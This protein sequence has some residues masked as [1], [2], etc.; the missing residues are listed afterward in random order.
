[1][2]EV[3]GSNPVSPTKH[4]YMNKPRPVLEVDIVGL[5]SEVPPLVT[6]DEYLEL[7]GP[8][9]DGAE[10]VTDEWIID[11]TGVK[12]RGMC[13]EDQTLADLLVGSSLKAINDAGWPE[14]TLIDHL[15][16]CSSSAHKFREIPL[17]HTTV[18]S[19]LAKKNYPSANSTLTNTACASFG[20]G[21]NDAYRRFG[22]G[23]IDRAIVVGGDT[24]SRLVDKQNADTLMMADGAG[25]V[26][27]ERT[28]SDNYEHDPPGA[29]A[30]YEGGDGSRGNHLVA[31][32]GLTL[33][34]REGFGLG[35]ASARAM[36][37]VSEKLLEW[38]G[39]T[40]EEIDIVIPHQPGVQIIESVKKR[41]ERKGLGPDK[42]AVTVDRFG[43]MSSGC[44]PV[45]LYEAYHARR[46]TPGN[47][48]ML[49]TV[50]AGINYAG[51]MI[52]WGKKQPESV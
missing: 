42:V 31:E 41:L 19:I 20:F 45:A 37:E 38:S 24:V 15:F 28:S 23:E 3:T 17:I 49:A 11:K 5:G 12:S 35:K 4:L 48:V 2:E 1:M 10:V 34:M 21:L 9:H 51:Q 29:L 14:G 52:R 27:L 6:N 22:N 44:I 16:V 7:Y 32:V 40:I 18:Q 36:L 43:N 30:Y 26:A 46:I 33:E 39:V 47:L 13:P 25:A 50:G 8:I